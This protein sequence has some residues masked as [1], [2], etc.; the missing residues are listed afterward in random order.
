MGKGGNSVKPPIVPVSSVLESAG[1]I[2]SAQRLENPENRT[3][4][5]ISN[6]VKALESQLL[7]QR[8]ASEAEHRPK[9]E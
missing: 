5:E 7:S 8:E 9:G 4:E 2:K 6:R 3:L 1:Q